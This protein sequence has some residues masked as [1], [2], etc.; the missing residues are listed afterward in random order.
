MEIMSFYDFFVF[1]AVLYACDL[2]YLVNVLYVNLKQNL[3]VSLLI[4]LHF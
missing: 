4:S 3:Q 1:L 2:M